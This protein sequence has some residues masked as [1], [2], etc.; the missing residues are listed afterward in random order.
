M[1]IQG[2]RIS[3]G[4]RPDRA[5]GGEHNQGDWPERGTRRRH[6]DGGLLALAVINLSRY[7]RRL[8]SWHVPVDAVSINLEEGNCA[9]V[10]SHLINP[11]VVNFM[12]LC[13]ADMLPALR[14]VYAEPSIV[15]RLIVVVIRLVTFAVIWWAP[16]GFVGASLV[17]LPARGVPRSSPS[18]SVNRRL[19]FLLFFLACLSAGDVPPPSVSVSS[20]RFGGVGERLEAILEKW[21]CW[22]ALR[23]ERVCYVLS[24]GEV[25][26]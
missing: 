23:Q 3:P 8:A 20:M 22:S 9:V 16:L 11:V 19:R 10:E 7:C 17:R 15:I 13:R 1:R 4:S 25:G 26:L 6:K 5:A 21:L 18:S 2:C 14:I 24:K 12:E